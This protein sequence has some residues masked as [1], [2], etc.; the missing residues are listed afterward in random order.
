MS[1]R[2]DFLRRIQKKQTEIAEMEREFAAKVQGEKRYLQAMYDA[3]KLLPKDGAEADSGRPAMLRKGSGTAKAYDALKRYGKPMHVTGIAEAIGKK[4]TRQ[5]TQGLA[6][7]MRAYVLKGEIF[8]KPA[9]NTYGLVEWG[10]DG[11][12][13]IEWPEDGSEL[14]DQNP[15]E[16]R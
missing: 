5:N 14:P 12:Q 3:L 6:S 15:E 16:D 7:S 4:A 2:T 13:V 1:L 11:N 9:P 10:A 8:T